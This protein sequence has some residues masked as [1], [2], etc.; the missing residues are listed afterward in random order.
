MENATKSLQEPER[1][2]ENLKQAK[3]KERISLKAQ[4]STNQKRVDDYKSCYYGINAKQ[5][6]K[7]EQSL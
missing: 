6:K 5:A 7:C 3:E 1:K 4:L 2:R